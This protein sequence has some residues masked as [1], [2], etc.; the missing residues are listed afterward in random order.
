MKGI[1]HSLQKCEGIKC[2][3]ISQPV[4]VEKGVE[5]EGLLFPQVDQLKNV[6]DTWEGLEDKEINKPLFL[7]ISDNE[8]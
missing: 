1:V 2:S 3:Y 6:H 4:L 8:F 5:R 7:G